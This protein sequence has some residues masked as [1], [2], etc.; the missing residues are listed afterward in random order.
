MTS[1]YLFVCFVFLCFFVLFFFF[2]VVVVVVVVYFFFCSDAS[3]S[4]NI[5]SPI[6]FRTYFVSQHVF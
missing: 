3:A 1:F 4:F 2:F 6:L 5:T